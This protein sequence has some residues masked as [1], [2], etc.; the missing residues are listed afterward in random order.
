M[1]VKQVMN[2]IL[3]AIMFLLGQVQEPQSL[4]LR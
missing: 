3:V 1:L 2:F 4:F